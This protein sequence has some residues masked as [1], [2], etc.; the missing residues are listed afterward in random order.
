MHLSPCPRDIRAEDRVAECLRIASY[1]RGSEVNDRDRDCGKSIG[2][3]GK[4]RYAAAERERERMPLEIP[5]DKSR[6]AKMN[7]RLG[8]GRWMRK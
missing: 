3:G 2:N 8:V 1:I 6:A 4:D 7:F 5:R